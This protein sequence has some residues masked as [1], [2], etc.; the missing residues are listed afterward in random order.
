MHSD[1]PKPYTQLYKT[2]RSISFVRAY[3]DV[4]KKPTVFCVNVLTLNSCILL[5][6]TYWKDARRSLDGAMERLW[7][8]RKR[9][10]KQVRWRILCKHLVFKIWCL[11][12]QL[13]YVSGISPEQVFFW[14]NIQK[15]VQNQQTVP[16]SG[17][18]GLA[19]RHRATIH[20]WHV[21]VQEPSMC[22]REACLL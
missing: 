1:V 19:T 21:I 6:L 15:M 18:D 5:S 22:L 12:F 17:N 11:N 14:S 3:C 16:I 9:P 8:L 20:F 7:V 2:V 4:K 10:Y 13:K